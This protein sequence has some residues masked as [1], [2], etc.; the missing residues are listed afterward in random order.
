MFGLFRKQ[1]EKVEQEFPDLSRIR[2]FVIRIERAIQQNPQDWKLQDNKLE[3]GEG[4]ILVHFVI[5]C[6]STMHTSHGDI[7]LNSHE[8]QYLLSAAK[9][10]LEEI[11]MEKVLRDL[12]KGGE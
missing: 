12:E 8:C 6:P 4:E 9:E 5:P 3:K 7:T 2:N 11:F 10:N 1:K